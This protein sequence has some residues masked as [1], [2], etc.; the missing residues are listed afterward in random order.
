MGSLGERDAT[1]YDDGKG[2][3]MKWLDMDAAIPID[4]HRWII[5]YMR[6]Y[7]HTGSVEKI[8]N[9][10]G[11]EV[12]V[13]Q[14]AIVDLPNMEGYKAF[15][16]LVEPHIDGMTPT[17]LKA[18][19]YAPALLVS[20]DPISTYMEIALD[21]KELIIGDYVVPTRFLKDNEKPPAGAWYM[22]SAVWST[23][24]PSIAQISEVLAEKG[25]LA[26]RPQS[27]PVSA[28]IESQQF[29]FSPG[30]NNV[31]VKEIRTILGSVSL[32]IN[33]YPFDGD[34]AWIQ[35]VE[36]KGEEFLKSITAF[37]AGAVDVAKSLVD[38]G[39]NAGEAVKDALKLVDFLLMIAVPTAV[40]GGGF[41]LYK[42]YQEATNE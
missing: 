10:T 2:L 37:G 17:M 5:L 13:I 31:T 38:T 28:V 42:K 18:E 30:Q 33:S 9:G 6:D 41:W 29:L 12:E 21:T 8:L 14:D 15:Y 32:Y 24:A 34:V 26:Y 19:V 23:N 22:A 27:F 36:G 20:E 4:E 16:G 39:K 25:M 7:H 40:V 3:V 11:F 35:Q 1:R